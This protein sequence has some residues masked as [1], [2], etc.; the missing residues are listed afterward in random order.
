MKD[1]KNYSLE[2]CYKMAYEFAKQF[3]LFKNEEYTVRQ[4][5]RSI[6]FIKS[7]IDE[8]EAGR[9]KG[10]ILEILDA[11]IDI[12]Y[13]S[14][15][16]LA[17]YTEKDFNVI[18]AKI[19][20]FQKGMAGISKPLYYILGQSIAYIDQAHNDKKAFQYIL[21]N[22]AQSAM[23]AAAIIAD[24]QGA[25]DCVHMANMS[26]CVMG[27]SEAA[28]TIK[29]LEKKYKKVVSYPISH[30]RIAFICGETGKLLKPHNWQAPDLDQYLK[31]C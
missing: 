12:A 24:A 13:F 22:F 17:K 20:E 18:S 28:I 10:D 21:I 29:H 16:E 5:E 7:E 2:S 8:L 30:G 1:S 14:L 4:F 27:Y 31:P 26:K 25:Y 23:R 9:V 3:K 15:F 19:A 6:E 11:Y